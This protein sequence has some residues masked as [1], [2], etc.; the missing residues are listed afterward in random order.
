MHIHLGKNSVAPPSSSVVDDKLHNAPTNTEVGLRLKTDHKLRQ[1]TG[2][3]QA[4]Q[5]L[6][7]RFYS[8]AGDCFRMT[9]ARLSHVISTASGVK[10]AEN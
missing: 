9:S 1:Q 3:I 8:Q 5:Q 6:L 7:L 2:L 10:A 4:T